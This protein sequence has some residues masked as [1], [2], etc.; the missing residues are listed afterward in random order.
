MTRLAYHS[1]TLRARARLARA[2]AALPSGARVEGHDSVG[3]WAAQ[4]SRDSEAQG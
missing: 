4:R 2:A 1:A 3:G